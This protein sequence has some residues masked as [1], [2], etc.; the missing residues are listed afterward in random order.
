ME[1][2]MFRLQ[3]IANTMLLLMTIQS[4]SIVQAQD[5]AQGIASVAWLSGSWISRDK[6]EI[7]EEQWMK[8]RGGMML[9]TNRTVKPQGKTAFEF[10]RISET[11]RGLTFY[12]SPSGKPA[13]PF[14]ATQIEDKRVVFENPQQD[15]PNKIIYSTDG[16][17]LF[18]TIE[19]TLD[20]RAM[21][22]SW[23][24]TRDKEADR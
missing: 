1:K 15:F 11:D 23:T 7:V 12:A 21:K 22:M 2:K 20:G 13:V 18:A 19:G 14:Q 5:N 9:G 17:K 3:T 16:D 4:A 6:G 8:P 10:M 24:W